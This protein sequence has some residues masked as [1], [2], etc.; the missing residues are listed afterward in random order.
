MES[1][2][3]TR[4]HCP[5]VVTKYPRYRNGHNKSLLTSTTHPIKGVG[6]LSMTCQQRAD[7]QAHPHALSD[8]NKRE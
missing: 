3:I 1:E 6:H 7:V 2:Q 8:N 4:S 5:C